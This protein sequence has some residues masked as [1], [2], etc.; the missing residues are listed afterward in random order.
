MSASH[1]KIILIGW[2][3]WGYLHK[4]TTFDKDCIL[5]TLVRTQTDQTLTYQ[6]LR[7]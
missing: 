4:A 3:E 6:N 2:A 5:L 1:A 7:I